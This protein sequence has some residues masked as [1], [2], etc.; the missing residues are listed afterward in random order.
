M[1]RSGVGG[2]NQLYCRLYCRLNLRLEY[3]YTI[4]QVKPAA[5]IWLET[6]SKINA[7]RKYKV[8]LATAN[9]SARLRRRTARPHRVADTLRPAPRRLARA[10]AASLR[11][12][13]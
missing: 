11:H 9:A 8:S 2:V 13:F 5:G 10:E 12:Y 1:L 6:I 7:L 3:G 4:L